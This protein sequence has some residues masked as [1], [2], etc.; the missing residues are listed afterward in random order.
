MPRVEVPFGNEVVTLEFADG[1]LLQPRAAAPAAK[2][3]P[4]V[5]ASVREALEAPTDFPPLRRALTPDDHVAITVPASLHQLPAIL[6]AVIEHVLSAGVR[7]QNITVLTSTG[8][9]QRQQ[10]ALELQPEVP[11]ASIVAHRRAEAAEHAY[12]AGTAA[13]RAVYLDRHLVDA[14]QV[15][16][17]G[18]IPY[19]SLFGYRGGLDELFP[20]FSNE[21][22]WMEF[23]A[24]P[25]QNLGGGSGGAAAAEAREI[26]WLLGLPFLVQVLEGPGDSVT[27]ILAGTA[28][29]LGARSHELLD[30]QERLRVG[31]YA[32]LVVATITGDAAQQTF[33]DIA[34]A[35]AV[36]SRVVKAGGAIAV[37]SRASVEPGPGFAYLS[38]AEAPV[39]GLRLARQ[40]H[41]A[42]LN[43][44]WQLATAA[45]HARLFLFSDLNKDTAQELFI[46]PLESPE[47]VQKLSQESAITILLPD[48]QRCLVKLA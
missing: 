3:L 32:D 10:L 37:L 1:A 4:D 22:T 39:D 15:I 34:R 25:P 31:R 20:T 44:I 35:F 23:Q 29:S 42:E 12:L 28:D 14:G 26:G 43:S 40:H 9:E 24:R 27:Q 45:E 48:A 5:A 46:T 41:A 36:A 13:G 47:Q 2:R 6:K 21:A 38:G 8:E 16:V 19:D 17:I 33:A 11:G 7:P 18:K 30:E